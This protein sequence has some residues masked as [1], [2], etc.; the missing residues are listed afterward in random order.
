MAVILD[1]TVVRAF[2]VP[3]LMILFGNLNW[4]ELEYAKRRETTR[5][6]LRLRRR[7]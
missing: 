6:D 2:L 3:A 5:R 1:A 7:C 4:W